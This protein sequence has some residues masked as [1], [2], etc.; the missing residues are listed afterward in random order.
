MGHTVSVGTICNVKKD[1]KIPSCRVP[2]NQKTT[3]AKSRQNDTPRHI[4][5]KVAAI[6]TRANP[7]TQREMAA[8]L[9]VTASTICRIIRKVLNAKLRKK[10]KAHKIS[11]AQVEK[12][13][14]RSEGLYR[15]V[16]NPNR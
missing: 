4:I 13:R 10:R 2:A 9:G 8:K 7:P 11:L 16:G 3:K 5:R 14:Q 6:I 1:I 15:I 12:R